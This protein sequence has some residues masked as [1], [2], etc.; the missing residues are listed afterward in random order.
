MPFLEFG[1]FCEWSRMT[2][3]AFLEAMVLISDTI[4]SFLAKLF[5]KYTVFSQNNNTQTP[6]VRHTACACL[7]FITVYKKE[8]KEKNK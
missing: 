1:Y 2:L 3:C 8:Y 7:Y 4:L 5:L 6:L